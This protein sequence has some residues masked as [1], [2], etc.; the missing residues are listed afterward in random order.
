MTAISTLDLVALAGYLVCIAA[1]GISFYDRKSSA[2]EYFLGGGKMNWVPVGISILAADLS[3]ISVMG[4][5]AWVYKHDLSLLWVTVGY[6]IIAPLVILVFAPFYSRQKLYTAYEYLERRFNL[7]VRILASGLFHMLRAWH[8]AVAIYGPALILHLV[9]GFDMLV[10][11]ATMGAFTTLYTAL[12]GMKAVI[13]TDVIQFGTVMGGIILIIVVGTLNVPGG[14][15]HVIDIAKAGGKLHF[16]NTAFDASQMT[17]IWACLI[18]G[19]FL[20]L[21]PL[22]T[23][24]AILQRLFSTKSDK[25]FGRSVFLQA[26]LIVPVIGTLNLVGIVLFAFYQTHPGHVQGLINVDA[27]VPFFVLNELPSGVAGLVIGGIFAASMAVMSA[28]INALA[29]ATTVD[30]YARI[31]DTKR[32]DI[33]YARVGRF[34][35]TAWGIIATLLAMAAAGASDLATAYSR[36]SSLLIGPML[37]M[38]LLGIFTRRANAKGVITGTLAGGAL[39]AVLSVSTDWSF[40]YFGAIGTIATV[41]GGLI[42]SMF[43]RAD[44][45]SARAA[46]LGLVL[47]HPPHLDGQP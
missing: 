26:I 28:G 17:S 33:H 6:P 41:L 2:K 19:I 13:W 14:A 37:G 39:T 42:A 7:H 35:T 45:H 30:F 34:A 27:I 22:T 23:D 12:G 9:S 21:G 5:P 43:F 31:Y 38:F 4:S 15:A 46:E 36:I 20:A 3:A 44:D 24:Q 16:V 29:T 8:V 25:D 10:C 32:S 40:L 47:A 18:G 11:I 1:F